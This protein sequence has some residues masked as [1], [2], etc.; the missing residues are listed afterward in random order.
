MFCK[1]I[2]AGIQKLCF[3]KIGCTSGIKIN[4]V[5]FVFRSVCTIFA[6]KNQRSMKP[7]V[8]NYRK[9]IP[10]G[11]SNFASVRRD[12]CYLVDKTEFVSEQERAIMVY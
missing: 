10:Y 3:A 12:D 1:N 5:Y 2:L 6:Q 4:A 7:T 11:M 9:R 8:P